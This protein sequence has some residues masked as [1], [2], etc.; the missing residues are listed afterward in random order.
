MRTQYPLKTPRTRLSIKNDPRIINGTKYSQLNN[1]PT[2]SLVYKNISNLYAIL[3]LD[4][5]PNRALVSNL[6]L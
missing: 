4:Y 3:S 2:A 1:V 5:I 6:P